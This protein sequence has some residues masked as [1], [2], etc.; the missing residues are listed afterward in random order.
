[1]D[2]NIHITLCGKPRYTLH[3]RAAILT[4]SSWRLQGTFLAL[5]WA[6]GSPLWED[7]GEHVDQTC[8]EQ[9]D[10]GVPWTDTRKFFMI[11]PI[12]LYVLAV[13]ALLRAALLISYFADFWLS[14][15]SLIT[16]K[17]TCSSMESY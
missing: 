9:I 12:V 4:T 8:W 11:V 5:H 10:N 16:I 3:E 7:Q 1:M 6:R 15:I 14:V 17:R 13:F 2:G